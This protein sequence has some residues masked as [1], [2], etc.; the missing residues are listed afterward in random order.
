[1]MHFFIIYKVF[2]TRKF[3]FKIF[4]AIFSCKIAIFYNA[5]VLG[6]FSSE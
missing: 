5:S 4:Y 3:H 2:S 1:M 6:T